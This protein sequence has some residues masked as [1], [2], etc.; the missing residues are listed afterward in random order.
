[1]K[2]TT[3]CFLLLFWCLPSVSQE[4][5]YLKGSVTDEN[6]EPLGYATVTLTN[7][8]SVLVKGSVT[9]STGHYVL[10]SIKDG[11]YILTAKSMGFDPFSTRIELKEKDVIIP[12][13]KLKTSNYF[14][15]GVEI[16]GNAFIRKDGFALIIPG[17]QQV[18]HASTGYEL[19]DN[20]MIP[21]IDV[22]RRTGVVKNFNGTVSM[23]ING[24]KADYREVRSLRPRD[25]EKIEYHDAPTGMYSNEKAVINYITKDYQTGGYISLDGRQ[26]IGYLNGDYNAAM[27][28]S[29]G[30]TIYKFFGGH[31]ISKLKSTEKNYEILDFKDYYITRDRN[32]YDAIT[33]TNGQYARFDMMNSTQK[34]TLS[35]KFTFARNGMPANNLKE[36]II[37]GGRYAGIES[38]SYTLDNQN[39]WMPN[40]DFMG[41][42]KIKSNQQLIIYLNGSYSHNDY[43]RDYRETEFKSVTSAK[44]DFYKGFTSFLYTIGMKHNNSLTLQFNHLYQNSKLIYTGDYNDRQQLWSAETFFYANYNHRINNKLTLYAHAG[45]SALQYKLLE[46]NLVSRLGPR[47]NGRLTIQPKQNQFLQIAIDITSTYPT[48]DRLNDVEQQIDPIMIKRGNPAMDNSIFYQGNVGYSA[49]FG[50]VNLMVA[51]AYFYMANAVAEH[52][53]TEQERLISSFSSDAGFQLAN[54]MAELTWK[55]T[56]SFNIKAKGQWIHHGLSRL[57]S[58]NRNSWLGGIILDYY[59]KD[60]KFNLYANLPCKMVDTSLLRKEIEYKVSYG[61]SIGWSHGGWSAEIGT[62][63]PFTA[64]WP[65]TTTLDTDVYQ[66]KQTR[67][68]DSMQQTGYVKL[69]YTF[70]FGKKTDRDKNDTNK[71]INSAILKAY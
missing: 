63:N 49:Q 40:I 65:V 57:V 18:K 30:N 11:E 68:A 51:G 54:V 3:L 22:N 59:L 37:Y 56:S 23:Y 39:S 36:N 21:G 44:E 13:I 24:Q 66:F 45:F 48:L 50:R 64:N 26:T 32:G 67:H 61:A 20:L 46:R 42:F 29:R 41:N 9:D 47:L 35:G 16:K 52:Y 25:I 8:D 19:L 34:R 62:N 5:H 38:S 60:W 70:D 33:E 55:V 10:N 6:N 69:S 2:N 17:K 31:T 43:N 27:K 71:M 14:L 12:G 15:D 1:M 53:Y 4:L 7:L 28:L 58:K